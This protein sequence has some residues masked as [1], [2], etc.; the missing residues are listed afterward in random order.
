MKQSRTGKSNKFCQLII[1]LKRLVNS[2]SHV[3]T[4]NNLASRNKKRMSS[5]TETNKKNKIFH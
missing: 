2:V 4:G 3:G 1:T 5:P